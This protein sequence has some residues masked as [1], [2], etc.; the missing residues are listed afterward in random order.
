MR[1]CSKSI[2][3]RM[4]QPNF[5][6]RYFAG[7]GIDIGGAPDPLSLYIDMFPLL[8]SVRVWDREDGDAQHMA[9]V[10]DGTYDFVHASHCLEH[11]HDPLEALRHWL[12]IT[13]PGGYVI[14]TVP[15]EDMYEQGVF[16]STHNRDHKA[17]FT[18][19]KPS[20]WS[21]VSVNVLDLV[22]DLGAAAQ[23]EK[24][25]LLNATF[26]DTLPRY[27]QTRTPVGECAI[28]FV[29]RKAGAEP[30]QA[31]PDPALR[32]HYNQYIDDART[33]RTANEGRP[34]FTNT[35]EL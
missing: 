20:S 6:R 11:M 31:Q 33:L 15:D 29:L 22:R 13:R 34:P 8:R 1:E 30:A 26:L 21:P 27:D 3:R 23:A 10:A 9:G 2:P 28:E 7:D 4:G 16:P 32:I 5:M 14:V 18:I 25:E 24:I 17:T 35:D 19:C 12:R